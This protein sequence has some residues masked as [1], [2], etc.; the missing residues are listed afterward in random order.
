[1]KKALYTMIAASVLSTPAIAK[2]DMEN[3]LYIPQ[4]GELY[5]KTSVGLGYRKTDGAQANQYINAQTQTQSNIVRITEQAGF[6]ITD[7]LSVN[8]QISYEDNQRADKTGLSFDRL[9]LTYRLLETDNRI[10]ADVYGGLE[11]GGLIKQQ[12]NFASYAFTENSTSDGAYGFYL[13]ARTGFQYCRFTNMI[14][15]EVTQNF[16][17]SNN[18]L[19]VGDSIFGMAFGKDSTSLNTKSTTDFAA[20]IKT[21]YFLNPKWSLG[22]GFTYKYNHS[23]MAHNFDDAGLSGYEM[24]VEEAK[25]LIN[26]FQNNHN[27]YIFSAQATHNFATDMQ[28][29]LYTD[30]TIDS[31]NNNSTFG[32]EYDVELGVRYNVS[33]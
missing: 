14:F 28:L 31:F 29:T 22:A 13:G 9:G 24:L 3:P 26:D 33:F 15:A 10:M 11:L 5:S 16:G 4:A 19:Y 17:N 27:E 18:S 12:T 25:I 6:G 23:Y 8:G 1:M 21:F 2:M 32:S 7:N 20:G 30:F